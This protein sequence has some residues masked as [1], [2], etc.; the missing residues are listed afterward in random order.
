MKIIKKL[1]E[2]WLPK[3]WIKRN[4]NINVKTIAKIESG[5]IVRKATKQ[6]VLWNADKLIEDIQTAYLQDVLDNK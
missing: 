6:L 2:L 3:Q 5:W 4:L 1:L